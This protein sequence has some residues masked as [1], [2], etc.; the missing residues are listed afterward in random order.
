MRTMKDKFLEHKKKNITKISLIIFLI[1]FSLIYYLTFNITQKTSNLN[2][3][4]LTKINENV[5]FIAY[6]QKSTLKNSTLF[7]N[8]TTNKSSIVGIIF[9]I[10][11][12]LS[13]KKYKFFGKINYY[14]LKPEIII[15]K[16]ENI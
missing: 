5:N 10:N 2:N 1:L 4:D 14:N 7:L 11:K 3:L 6:V 15:T 12:T 13:K 16:I 8:L 9:N